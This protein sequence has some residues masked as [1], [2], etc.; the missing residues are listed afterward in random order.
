MI[1]ADN[2]RRTLQRDAF[3]YIDSVTFRSL[4]VWQGAEQEDLDKMEDG[5]FHDAVAKD[6]EASMAFRQ[7]AFHRMISGPECDVLEQFQN[8]NGPAV[9]QIDE[10][11]IASDQGAR[12]STKRSGIKT[13][14]MPPESYALS[15]IPGALSRVNSII[16]DF[17]KPHEPQPRINHL[18]PSLILDQLLIKINK[19]TS[20]EESPT[21]EGV[22]Q[23]GTEV[24]SVTFI[25]RKGVESGGESLFWSKEAPTGNYDGINSNK[26]PILPPAGFTWD[27][28]IAK[29]TL[30]EPW[31][32][33]YFMDRR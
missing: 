25:Q 27:N 20:A 22:H 28:L 6:A 16:M 13:W 1:L 31:E 17:N 29:Q 8:A 5:S 12:I 30:K 19:T 11:E 15:S 18:S 23:D 10:G 4:L 9:T 3:V 32:T 33:I 2:I 14:N 21:P 24:S 26:E 7:I